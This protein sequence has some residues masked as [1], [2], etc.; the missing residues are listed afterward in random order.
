MSDNFRYR[1]GETKP[2]V[3]KAVVSATVVEV[4]DLVSNVPAAAA[5]TTWDTNIATTQEAFHDVFLGVSEQRSRNGDTA[6]L[7]LATKGVFEFDCASATFNLGT[8]VGAAKQTGN[9]LESQKVVAVA[10][11]NLA[12]GRVAKQY[13][14][15][16]TKVQVEINSTICNGGPYAP[17]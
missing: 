9:L 11:A 7:R 5:A 10:T 16:T 8:L 12:V 17:A 6:T 2:V 1:H 3:S 13:D 4:G 15:A 14:S